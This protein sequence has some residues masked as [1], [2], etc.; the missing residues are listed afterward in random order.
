MNKNYIPTL[1]LAPFAGKICNSLNALLVPLILVTIACAQSG[2]GMFTGDSRSAPS[3]TYHSSAS[4]V[5]LVFFTTGEN[6][7]PVEKLQK[8]DFAVVD[9]EKVIREFRSFTRSAE[10]NLDVVVLIDASGS[11]LPRF[12]QEIANVVKLISQG[13]WTP[14]DNLAV[15]SF[16][17]T[18]AHLICSGDCRGSFTPDRVV[19]WGG[20][21]A[22]PL[23]D[24]VEMAAELLAHRKQPDFW[25]VI[26]L[27]SDGD[28]NNSKSSFVNARDKVMASGA[29]VYAID[30][31]DPRVVGSKG[32][33]TLQRIAQD[34]G[35]RCLPIGDGAVAIFNGVAGDLRSAHVVTYLAPQSDSDFHSVRILPTHNLNLQFRSR[36]GYY[37]RSGNAH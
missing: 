26:I 1:L 30:V 4:E 36:R 2:V 18:E 34:S 29:Q 9:D 3:L 15:L 10:A 28:D 6:N 23:F 27:F 32:K 22:T 20:G 35:G 5:R 33:A 21:G 11:V 37:Q 8:D 25:P 24:A 19:P 31:G 12:R 17:G 14:Q 13:P 16:S 7:Q